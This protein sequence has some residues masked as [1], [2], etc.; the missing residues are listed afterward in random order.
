M[1]RFPI[2]DPQGRLC[3]AGVQA[4]LFSLDAS[5]AI[6]GAIV[7]STWRGR[8]Y[9]RV[10]ATP[11]NPKS[12]GQQANRSMMRYLSTTWA[13]LSAADQATWANLATQ[14]N[15]SRSNAFT[16]FNMDRWKQYADPLRTPTQAV[17]TLPTMGALTVTG[18]VGQLSVSQVITTAADIWGMEV[19]LSLTTGFTPVKTTVVYVA[20]F[21]ASPIDV[22]ISPLT[23]G[24]YFVRT[25]GFTT[26][27]GRTA[28]VAQQSGVVT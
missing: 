20:R 25:A 9:V 8:K 21:T 27:G 19:H 6:A 26:G 23:P 16:K 3:L 18:G 28:Y 5:G 14:G 15:Y 1:L 7:Y 12:G 10:L 22:I 13:T 2:S 11:S 4:P 24:T 17:G